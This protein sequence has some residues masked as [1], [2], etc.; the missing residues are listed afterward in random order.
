MSA[1]LFRHTDFSNAPA[2]PLAYLLHERKF[3][4]THDEFFKEIRGLVPEIN[5]APNVIL[6]TDG[7]AAI[8][9]AIATNFPSLKSFLCW[10][11]LIQVILKLIHIVFLSNCSGYYSDWE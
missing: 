9:S 8:A 7:E 1:L 11:H 4:R 2:L 3:A 10:N 6:V 5:I